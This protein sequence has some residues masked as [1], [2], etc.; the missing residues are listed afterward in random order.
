MTSPAP[1]SGLARAEHWLEALLFASR[2]LMAPFY[3]G[4]VIAL[5]MLL[6][7]FTY[8]LLHG[9]MPALR[10]PTEAVMLALTLIELSLVGNLVL[11]VIFSGYEGFVS[12]IDIGEHADRPW[13][14]GTI[15]FTGM[16]LKVMG[17]V[18]AISAI[19]LLRGF[20]R[21]AEETRAAEAAG[22]HRQIDYDRIQWALTVHGVLVLTAVL[23]ALTE[24]IGSRTAHA[25]PGTDPH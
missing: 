14:M 15:G 2:W 8:D 7:A 23:F 18:V 17:S 4:L 3:L 24:W 13:W 10:A 11:I 20:V 5:G 6:V 21:L 19:A 22:L 16:K 12:R 9:L 25:A 1:P